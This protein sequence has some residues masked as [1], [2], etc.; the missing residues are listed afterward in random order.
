MAE[1]G[2]ML[3]RGQLAEGVLVEDLARQVD[4]R[5]DLTE[6]F[7]ATSYPDAAMVQWNAVRSDANVLRGV[8]CHRRHHD[9][10]VVVQGRA[11]IGLQDLRPSSRTVGAAAVVEVGGDA[12]VSIAIPPGVAHGFYFFEPSLHVYGVSEFWDVAD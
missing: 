10:I 9:V 6:I 1:V 2:S 8:H 5:G 3:V 7:R 4:H 12:P 11:A